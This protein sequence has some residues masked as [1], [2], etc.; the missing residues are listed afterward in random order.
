MH[1][2]KLLNKMV[3]NGAIADPL[4]IKV[5]KTLV[6]STANAS[7]TTALLQQVGLNQ[8]IPVLISTEPNILQEW[9]I[10]STPTTVVVDSELKFV[11][12]IVGLPES[13]QQDS[14]FVS[15][16]LSTYLVWLRKLRIH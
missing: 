2:K 8:Q 3:E 11:G 6:V 13:S 5:Q 10:P 15:D 7:Q 16:S 1:C 14:V 9:G 12:H 4:N